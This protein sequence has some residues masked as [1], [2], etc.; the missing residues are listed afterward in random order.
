MLRTLEIKPSYRCNQKCVFC[1]WEARKPLQPLAWAEVEA[2]IEQASVTIDPRVLVLSGGEP[3][4]RPDFGA[5]LALAGRRLRLDTFHL[6]TNGAHVQRWLD[7]LAAPIA[8]HKSATVGLHGHRADLHDALTGRP[9]SFAVAVT[10]VDSLAACG[11]RVKVA[12]VLCRDTVRHIEPLTDFLLRL[13]VDS[14]ELRLPV[15][16]PDRDLADLMPSRWQLARHLPGW[17]R[18]FS[19][20][21]QVR[22]LAA[23]AVCFGSSGLVAVRPTSYVCVA[24]GCADQ[25]DCPSQLQAI[26]GEVFAGYH[27]SPRCRACVHDA[28]CRGFSPAE[29]AAG[30][31]RFR[32]VTPARVL[33][34]Y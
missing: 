3:T 26:W 13:K 2:A 23:D 27:K 6:H 14:V 15:T 21:P 9:G 25:A 7:A 16:G 32:P 1:I 12:C 17:R 8:A 5:I 11:F 31:A 4:V 24:P 33:G 20:S 34:R 10:A 29:V 18:R 28:A 30:L 19:A 22:L